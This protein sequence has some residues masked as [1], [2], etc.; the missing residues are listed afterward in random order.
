MGLHGFKMNHASLILQVR[1]LNLR[2]NQDDTDTK[3]S[4]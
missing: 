2:L 3:L 4:F 1:I